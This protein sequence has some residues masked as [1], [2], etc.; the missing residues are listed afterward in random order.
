MWRDAGDIQK[1]MRKPADEDTHSVLD[2]RYYQE[3]LANCFSKTLT[4][5]A[6]GRVAPAITELDLFVT[7]TDT[8][9]VVSTIY[10]ELGHPIDVK[11]HR[12]MFQLQYRAMPN[13]VR[14][15]DFAFGDADERTGAQIPVKP[16]A[17][18]NCR[19]SLRGSCG[20]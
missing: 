6:N 5:P 19:D 9:G 8:H 1:L 17:W 14:K 13:W 12:A 4:T 20:L 16:D 15:N 10:D 11:K 2:S 18:P 3:Q 7:G